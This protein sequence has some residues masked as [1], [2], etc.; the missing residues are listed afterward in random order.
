MEYKTIYDFENL[1]EAFKKA[2]AGKS[3][4]VSASM[5]NVNLLE[6]LIYLQYLLQTKQYKPSEYYWFYVYEP[7]KRLVKTNSF[8]DKVIQHVLCDKVIEPAL[9]NKFIKDS[10]AS[11]AGKGTHFGLER[12]SSFLQGYF[13]SNKNREEEYRRKNGLP[14]IDVKAGGY[15]NGYVLKGD[16]RKFFYSIRHSELKRMVERYFKDKDIKELIF[17]IIDSDADPGIPIGNQT[18]QWLALLFLNEMDHIIKERLKI[19]YYGRYMDDFYI[20]SSSKEELKSTLE[21]LKE[22][23]GAIGL[24]LNQ[25]TQI[26]PLRHGIDFLGFHTYLTDT[27][28]VIRKLRRG[29]KDKMRKKIR[30]YAK[31]LEEGK[32][33][34]KQVEQSYQSWRNHA[35]HGNC[36]YLIKKMDSYFNEKIK[37]SKKWRK[38]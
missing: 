17:K 31:M 34:L 24:E 13:F 32:I 7:K 29:S 6:A 28:K 33:D 18:S 37:E 35:K 38:N 5:F 11:Q 15:A 8:K 36:Y 26:F 3:N 23:L 20:I 19:K 1:L 2:K 30:K 16:V 22:Y 25:K 27:G 9:E 21:T 10:Y 14:R 4:S 12:L